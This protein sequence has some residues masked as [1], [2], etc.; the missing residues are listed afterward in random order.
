MM[1]GI[2]GTLAKNVGKELTMDNDAF[3]YYLNKKVIEQREDNTSNIY[4]FLCE[5]CNKAYITDI[6]WM[7]KC[8]DCHKNY[9][10]D[11]NG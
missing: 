1:D 9:F 11:S 6:G 2:T 10:E 3:S 8:D 4:N 7:K 5:D